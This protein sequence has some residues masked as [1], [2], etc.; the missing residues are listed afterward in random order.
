MSDN[1]SRNTPET[2]LG[3]IAL[4]LSGGGYR[5]AAFHLGTLS[6][7]DTL[8]LLDDVRVLST[9]SGGTIAGASWAKSLADRTQFPEFL[10][11]FKRFFMLR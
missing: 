7:L 2:V 11:A 1:L 3:E 9:V 6:M 4:S 8:D 5:A 10:S